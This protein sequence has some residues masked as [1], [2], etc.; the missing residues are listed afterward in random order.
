MAKQEKTGGEINVQTFNAEGVEGYIPFIGPLKF[1]L[2][3][4]ASGIKSGMSYTGAFN[5]Q[6]LRQKA[7]FI[8]MTTSG[9]KESNVHGIATFS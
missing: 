8:Q 9:F 7:K 3:N 1:V 4:F 6:Q 5:L 2:Q